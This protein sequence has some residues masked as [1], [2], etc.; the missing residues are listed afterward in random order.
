MATSAI[1]SSISSQFVRN[2]SLRRPTHFTFSTTNLY[3]TSS[4]AS[5]G[6]RWSNSP[7]SSSSLFLTRRFE[8][9]DAYSKKTGDFGFEI[10]SFSSSTPTNYVEDYDVCIIGC[11][12]GG[13]AAAMRAWDY[14]KSVCVIE[15]SRLGGTGKVKCLLLLSALVSSHLLFLLYLHL[16]RYPQWSVKFKNHVGVK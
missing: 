7:S 1:L 9:T 12:P 4:I 10:D 13:F 2:A 6:T 11:G 14:G 16:H 15:K 8:H 3:S 5:L